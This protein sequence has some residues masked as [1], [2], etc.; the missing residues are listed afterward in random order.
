[1]KSNDTSLRI[2]AFKW[3]EE[4]VA[5]YGDVLPRTLLTDGFNHD[6][7]RIT[8]LGPQ[9]IWKPKSFEIPLSIVTINDGPYKDTIA[10]NGLLL[11]KYSGVNINNWDNVA[12]RKAMKQQ[13]PLIYF[14]NLIKG[15]GLYHAIWPVFI[16]GDDPKSL[17]FTVAADDISFIKNKEITD[18]NNVSDSIIEITRRGYITSQVKIR[19]HQRSF[20]EKVLQAY[21]NK[22]TLC[23]LKHREL[24]DA[25]HIIPDS[26]PEGEPLVTNGLS[27][28]KLHHAAFDNNI[29]GIRPDYSIEV[30]RDVLDENDGPMLQHG[31]KEMNDNKIILPSIKNNYPDLVLIE[32]RYKL[33][34]K[35]G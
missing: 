20:R 10:D 1:M 6:G 22:C 8:F 4:Q 34:L 14:F 26:D 12:L 21:D 35:A 33:F 17:T 13:V 11:Y 23:R 16:T 15:K 28:C 18:Y 9:G 30:R 25:A 19:L 3:L 32:K 27:L 31:I 7:E 29:I 2:V 24:L 5:I